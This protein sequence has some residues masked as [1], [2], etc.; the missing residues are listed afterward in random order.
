MTNP[1]TGLVKG[2]RSPYRSSSEPAKKNANNR[3]NVTNSPDIS[4]TAKT[5]TIPVAAPNPAAVSQRLERNV[6]LKAAKPMRM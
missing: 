1:A 2:I 3:A 5:I 4:V 6:P